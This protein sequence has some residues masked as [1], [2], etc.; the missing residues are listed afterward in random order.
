MI[1]KNN[2]EELI[3]LIQENP[4]L[5]VV[6]FVSNEEIADGYG[7]TIMENFYCK[8][9]TIWIYETQWERVFYD[10]FDEIVERYMDELYEEP[11]YKNLSDED[12]EE[13]IKKYVIDNIE[14]YEAIIISIS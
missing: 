7:S 12:Y 10:D 8:V 9:D 14:H 6:F 3:K 11:E 5:P 4:K 13:C 2:K 1:N